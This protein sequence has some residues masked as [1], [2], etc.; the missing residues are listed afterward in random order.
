[1]CEQSDALAPP[2]SQCHGRR[3]LSSSPGQPEPASPAKTV[4]EKMERSDDK[5]IITQRV[6]SFDDPVVMQQQSRG[7]RNGSFHA[8]GGSFHSVHIDRIMHC[9][10]LREEERS[11]SCNEVTVG[12]FVCYPVPRS[13]ACGCVVESIGF[14]L[15]EWIVGLPA[16]PLPR[17]K[18]E[19]T[20][21]LTLNS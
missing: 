16:K 3:E 21:D 11:L 8:G 18:T 14:A 5:K 7:R 15:R 9:T 6:V 4:A 19:P 1:M 10:V 13:G 17:G 2:V 12:K 20:L